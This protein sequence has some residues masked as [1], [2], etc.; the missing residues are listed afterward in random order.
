MNIFVKYRCS[1]ENY[2]DADNFIEYRKRFS[3]GAFWD[4]L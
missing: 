2:I 4:F 3:N 1:G